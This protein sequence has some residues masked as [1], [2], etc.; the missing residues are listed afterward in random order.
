MNHT[1]RRSTDR[2]TQQGYQRYKTHFD[3]SVQSESQ[4]L[5]NYIIYVEQT[6]LTMTTTEK[7]AVEMYSKLLPQ[8]LEPFQITKVRQ[9]SLNID[10]N[11]VLNKISMDHA[12]V[13]LIPPKQSLWATDIR[14]LEN[15]R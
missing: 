3:R 7:H 14:Q 9:H 15:Y 10:H 8:T 6:S 5:V 4:L 12:T 1:M 13:W 2:S 11:G